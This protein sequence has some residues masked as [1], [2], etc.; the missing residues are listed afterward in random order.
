[1][2]ALHSIPSADFHELSDGNKIIQMLSCVVHAREDGFLNAN[3]NGVLTPYDIFSRLKLK[4][5]I[6]FLRLPAGLTRLIM[7]RSGD[8]FFDEPFIVTSAFVILIFAGSH[9]HF[10]SG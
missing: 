7:L 6:S 5:L 3:L 2:G 9:W 1:M 10:V 4:S 8:A